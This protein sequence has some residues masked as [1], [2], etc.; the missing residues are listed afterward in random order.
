MLP[1]NSFFLITQRKGTTQ[2]TCLY[3]LNRQETQ[4]LLRLKLQ[5]MFELSVKGKEERR[6]VL[7]TSS[8]SSA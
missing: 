8:L 6:T 3:I 2:E 4:T 7:S 1:E 5:Q